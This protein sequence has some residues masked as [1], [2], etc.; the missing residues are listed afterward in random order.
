MGSCRFA[1]RSLGPL[2]V[3][4]F[5]PTCS[6]NILM[7]LLQAF[8]CCYICLGHTDVAGVHMAGVLV[9]HVLHHKSHY[10]HRRSGVA[11]GNL[12]HSYQEGRPEGCEIT[13][14]YAMYTFY[15]RIF[16]NKCPTAATGSPSVSK[17]SPQPSC[18]HNPKVH[19]GDLRCLVRKV[20]PNEE[21]S[22]A[23]RGPPGP[24]A[25]EGLP[26]SQTAIRVQ[27]LGESLTLLPEQIWLL[28]E[29]VA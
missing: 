9:V 24:Q 22:W 28:L 26:P 25:S 13:F 17:R 18:H 27:W 2:S 29:T 14:S 6:Y 5:S 15:C 12:R 21:D 3:R 7:G 1:T 16:C 19:G 11:P 23:S 4:F 20:T 10:E 8:F